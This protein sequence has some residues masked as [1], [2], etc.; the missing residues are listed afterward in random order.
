MTW[1]QSGERVK[2]IAAGLLA[3]GVHREERVGIL[4]NTRRRVAARRP[5]HPVRGRRDHDRLPVEHGRGVR[6]HPRRLGDPLRVR[7]GCQAGRQAAL[8]QGRDA[9]AREGDPDRWR[10]RQAGRRLD[11]DP[12]GPR[13]QGRRDPGEGSARGRRGRRRHR[14]EP[15]GDL[16][17]HVRHHR[18]AQGRAPA[19]RLLGVLRRRDRGGP[20]VDRQRRPVPVAADVALVRQGA[21]GR[22]HRLG[23][24]HRGRRPDPEA[25][26]Q[27]RGRPAD[28]GGRGAADLREGLQPDHREVEAGQPAQAAH[29]PVGDWRRQGGLAAAPAGSP[30]EWLARAPV[31]A[32]RPARVRQDQADVRR[33]RALLHLGLGAAVAR[34]RRVLPCVRRADPRGLWPHRDQRGELRQ[35]ADRSTR[36]ARSACRCRAPTASSRPRTARS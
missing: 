24:G 26:R 6:V 32:R 29:L 4:C 23:L 33:P 22:A 12:R 21:D 7:R 30:A 14:G 2:A 18:K 34:D 1:R 5:R 11:D 35:P 8:A 16:D 27:P 19:P 28:A 9:G 36:S 17:L 25:R 31:E 13:G 10:R 3:L 20:A 15:P